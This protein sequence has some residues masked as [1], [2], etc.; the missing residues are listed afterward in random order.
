MFEIQNYESFVA[1]ILVFQL[2]PGPGT[3]AILNA[4]ARN[5]ITAGLGA[6]LGTLLG[7]MAYMIAAI[8]G[9]AAVMKANPA[10]FQG[11]Q[12]FGVAYLGWMGLQ[13]LRQPVSSCNS[14]PETRK[15]AW[16]YFRQAFTVSLTNPKVVLFFVAFFPL[17]LRADASAL[18]L[19]VMIAHVTLI[20][21]LYQA[22]LVLV[23]N[24]VARRLRSLP[25]VRKLATRLA[26]TALLGF[27]VKLALDNR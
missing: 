18:T 25:L 27:G 7:D 17:F 15:S 26:G 23:G 16:V 11:L 21:F 4:T 24:A 1:A 9:L 10:L 8:V 14:S 5:G 2:I 6:V 20:S 22:G 12:W 3:L 13:L 19:G